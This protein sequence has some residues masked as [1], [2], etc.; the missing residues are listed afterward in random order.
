MNDS[1][2]PALSSAV[3][4]C[5]VDLSETLKSR[6]GEHKISAHNG[7]EHAAELYALGWWV[8]YGVGSETSARCDHLVCNGASNLLVQAMTS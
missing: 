2:C 4:C 8:L 3:I 5:E 7:E 1:L 6:H